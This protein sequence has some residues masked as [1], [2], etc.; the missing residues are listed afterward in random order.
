MVSANAPAHGRRL[1]VGA[2]DKD[3]SLRR[4]GSPIIPHTCYFQRMVNLDRRLTRAGAVIAFADSGG[5]GL[6]VVFTHGAGMDHSMF[7]AQADALRRQGFR[8]IIWDMRGH[9]ASAL[10]GGVRFLGRDALDDLAALLAACGVTAPVLVGHSLG[11]NLVQAFAREHPGRVGA[12]VVLD[13]TWNAGPLT[14]MERVALRLAA[15]LLSAVPAARLPR[16]MARASAVT[17]EASSRAEAVFARMPKSRFVDVWRATASFVDPDPDRRFLAPLA[18]LRG[19]EDA[20]GNIATA[21]PRWAAV[22]GVAE[23]VIPNA[24]H[25][26]TW[27]AADAVTRALLSI[28]DG[29]RDE[30]TESAG[31]S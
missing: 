27:D 1:F 13:S 28:L 24:G 15:P 18:L 7:D 12:A 2:G 19:A 23:H 6:P 11:G 29:W 25:I 3:S 9:G 22:E 26:V 17:P 5:G 30:L 20:T 10:S 14:R 8:V 16:L 21:M 4:R 31:R